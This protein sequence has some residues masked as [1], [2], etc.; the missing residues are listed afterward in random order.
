MGA[1]AAI[2]IEFLFNEFI[3]TFNRSD[4]NEKIP[5]RDLD[6]T[7]HTCHIEKATS[8]VRLV[9]FFT[10]ISKKRTSCGRSFTLTFMIYVAIVYYL[11]APQKPPFRSKIISFT[12]VPTND[13]D[14]ANRKFFK[15]ASCTL[16]MRTTIKSFFNDCLIDTSSSSSGAL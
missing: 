11:P 8:L 7:T 5:A 15:A 9:M 10:I 6:A 3:Y 2:S 16:E 13:D 12:I 4:F 1:A 14:T